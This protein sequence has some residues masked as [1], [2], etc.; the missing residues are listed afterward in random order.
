LKA[1]A[2]E[3]YDVVVAYDMHQEI[4]EDAKANFLARLKD[5]KGLVVMHHA[6]AS[7][8]AWPEYEKIIGAKYYLAKTN[9]NGVEKARSVYQHDVQIAVRVADRSHPITAGIQDFVI[10]DETYKLF[11]VAP[12]V[13]PLLT[14]TEPLSNDVIAWC[15]TYGSSRVVYIQCG[16]DHYAYENPNFQRLLRQ[17]I[18]WA[19]KRTE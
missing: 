1:D 3:K 13:H 4:T 18:Q 17:A 5:G 7:Y 10:H 15:K 19:A 11:D 16:H 14:T 2:A 8:Q 12:E 6:I 9:V